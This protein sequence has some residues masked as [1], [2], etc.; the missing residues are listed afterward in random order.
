MLGFF[1]LY[2]FIYT[3]VADHYQYVASIGIIILVVNTGYIVINR[4]GRYAGSISVVSAVLILWTLGILTWRQCYI[5][6]DQEA[7]WQ[8]TIHKNP[9]SVMAHINL[10]TLYG[11]QGR[12][13]EAIVENN[14]AL[15]MMPDSTKAY[16]NL[17]MIF[18]RKGNL[19]KAIDYYQH[20]LLIKP[21]N[22][23]AQNNLGNALQSKGDFKQA[24]H[25]YSEAL[26][27]RPNYAEAHYNLGV[28][29][30]KRNLLNEAIREY[31]KA[32]KI[33][34]NFVQAKTALAEAQSKKRS[35]G[36]GTENK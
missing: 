22:A 12:F 9:D 21:E 23:T 28:L 17:G 2:T 3:Y 6:K 10:G 30:A 4:F 5:Y 20:A 34:P 26:R 29:L 36:A 11:K 33:N 18:E 31:T 14:K 7:L 35:S 13:D 19:D 8:D 25:H 1:S 32:L 24:M 27:I 15:Q 16:N